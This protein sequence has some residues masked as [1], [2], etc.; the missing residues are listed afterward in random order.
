MNDTDTD[1]P[2]RHVFGRWSFNVASGDLYDG[3]TTTRLEPQVAKLL[4]HFLARQHTVISRDELIAAVWAN[5]IVSDDAINRCISILRHIL[6]PEDKHAYIETVVR[7]GYLAHFPPSPA[8]E[9]R[10]AWPRRRRNYLILVAFAGIA[11][12][13]LYSTVGQY[14]IGSAGDNS[15]AVLPFANLSGDSSQEYFADGMTD[16]LIA[17][18]GKIEALEVISRT[19]VMRF[20]GT[21]LPLPEVAAALGARLIVEASAQRD[22]ERVQIIAKLF[23]GATDRELW[24]DTFEGDFTDVLRLQSEMAQQIARGIRA[25]ITPEEAAR[26]AAHERV[27]PAAYDAYLRGLEHLYR[28][29]P[30]E[31][32]LA[33]GYFEQAMELAPESALGY[34]SLAL[35]WVYRAQLGVVPLAV[36]G[37][38]VRGY[39]ENAE[40]IDDQL[41]SSQL[42]LGVV[43]YLEWQIAESDARARRAIAIA[44][45]YT[46][47]RIILGNLRLVAGDYDEAIEQ[48]TYAVRLDPFNAFYKMLHGVALMGA[49]QYDASVASLHEALEI[50]PNLPTGWLNLSASLHLAGRFD[51]AIASER[52]WLNVT[53][54][55]EGKAALEEGLAEG[56][57]AEAMRRVAQVR[58]QRALTIGAGAM[59]VARHYSRAGDWE[60]VI[61]WLERAFEQRDPNVLMIRASPEFDAVR[62]DPRV[63]VLIQRIV[64]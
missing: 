51:E 49:R 17:N 40:R 21:E 1:N 13:I 62:D 44:P 28:L 12:V 11:A 55:V 19:S 16:A 4:A 42:A 8:E 30:P 26:L 22:G 24:T 3:E 59:G 61:E 50:A 47:A 56:G 23:D 54:N 31:L 29:A 57:Y 37:P 10:A 7:R 36:A 34:S 39:A 64:I 63:Q 5:R 52:E 60:K 48:I 25:T 6:S 32:D 15:I 43:A 2:E 38:L 33:E 27:D 41:A 45:S 9:L 53:R 14:I 18:L 58:A 20:K 46:D 35:T